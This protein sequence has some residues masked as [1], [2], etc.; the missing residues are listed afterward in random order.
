MTDLTDTHILRLWRDARTP[1]M[2]GLVIPTDPA[3]DHTLTER[4]QFVA[5]LDVYVHALMSIEANDETT[6][7]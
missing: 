5:A 3:L 6:F 4:D 2:A 1:T 7:H